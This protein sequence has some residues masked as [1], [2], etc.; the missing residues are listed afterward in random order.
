MYYDGTWR[1]SANKNSY[2]I[3][4]ANGDLNFE[5]ALNGVVGGGISRFKLLQ[6]DASANQVLINRGFT[7]NSDQGAYDFIVNGDSGVVFM[8][9]ASTNIVTLDATEFNIT[10]PADATKL[11]SQPTGGTALAVATTKYVDDSVAGISGVFTTLSAN[12]TLNTTTHRYIKVDTSAGDVTLTLPTA[13]NGTHPYDI[14]K[15]SSD[16]NTVTVVRSGA[17]T[18]SGDTSAFWITQYAH[19]EFFPDG[20]TEWLIK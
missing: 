20:G 13:T 14:W 18:I 6:L 10:A 4:N 19:N 5:G 2:N 9:D 17:D 7:S 15:T 11:S 8:L 1:R 3:Y 16:S 12:T